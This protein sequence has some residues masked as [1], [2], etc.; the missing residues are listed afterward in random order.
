MEF[1]AQITLK[2]C[3]PLFISL[4]IHTGYLLWLQYHNFT[5]A[6]LN[7]FFKSMGIQA[8]VIQ[9]L[10]S[11]CEQKGKFWLKLCQ[12]PWGMAVFSMAVGAIGEWLKLVP[13]LLGD[14]Q[15]ILILISDKYSGQGP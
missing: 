3:E 14:E 15:L 11:V 6:M 9:Y 2:A 10:L 8:S 12:S 7:I 13:F 1:Y 4:M 5:T